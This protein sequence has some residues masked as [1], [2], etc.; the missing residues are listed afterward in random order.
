MMDDTAIDYLCAAFFVQCVD[1]ENTGFAD[2]R[3]APS[4]I[5]NIA[6]YYSVQVPDAV[7][8]LIVARLAQLGAIDMVEDRYTNGYF[9]TTPRQV[10]EA[11]DR[12]FRRKDSVWSLARKLG[13]DW[14]NHVFQDQRFQAAIQLLAD[15]APESS[16]PAPAP[17]A[18]AEPEPAAEPEQAEESADGMA[19]AGVT[20]DAEAESEAEPDSQ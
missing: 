7:G 1:R 6:S 15:G 2:A 19:E 14:L 11:W 12:L 4:I 16:A 17:R 9:F 5:G 3:S 8:D 20:E 18:Q 10:T 13:D